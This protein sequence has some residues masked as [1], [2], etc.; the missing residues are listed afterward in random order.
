MLRRWVTI[1][2]K[3]YILLTD[4]G[5]LFTKLIKLYTKKS[6]NHASITFDSK[7]FE[8]YSFGRKNVRNSLYWRIRKERY[9]G[10][11]FN[12]AKCAIYSFEVTEDQYDRMKQYIR[13]MEVQKEEYRYN[14]LGLLGFIMNRPIKRKNAFFCS[15]FVAS[16][17]KEGTT[18]DFEKPLPLIAPHD[19]QEIL[20]LQLVYEG[21]L[22]DY[23]N[24]N[25]NKKIRLVCQSHPIGV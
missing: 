16:V 5:T 11:L 17:L 8:V 3:G 25:G 14:L 7:L 9:H 21:E 10:S 19:L 1:A 23:T 15:Q 20:N 6:Y 22:K 24:K 13:N 2:N 12:Q 18:I 4:T